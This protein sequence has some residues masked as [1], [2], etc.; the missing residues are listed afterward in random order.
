MSY[1]DTRLKLAQALG[2]FWL[3]IFTDQE[4]VEGYVNSIAVEFWDLD[5]MVAELPDYQSRYLLPLKDVA[6]ARLFL[7]D[8]ATLDRTQYVY[9]GGLAYGTEGSY[10][11]QSAGAEGWSYAI[12]ETLVPNFL[13]V[14]VLGNAKI[15]TLNVDYTVADG[16][17]LFRDNPLE[18]AGLQILPVAADGET[19]IKFLLWG[20]K[21]ER[22]LRAV[23][24][25]FGVIGGVV[26]ASTRQYQAAVNIA[27]DLRVD[28]ASKQNT[29]R[30][31]CLITDTDY[32]AQAGQVQ[33]V[34]IEGD[35]Q[36]VATENA[37][38][39]APLGATV[40]T[41]KGATL[42][43]GDLIF[44]SYAVRYEKEEVDFA[45]FGG[46]LLDKGLLGPGYL[47]GVF[48]GNTVV[49]VT[50]QHAPDWSYVEPVI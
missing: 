50:K 23:Q 15:L 18:I 45:D 27:W 49:P 37:V 34:F 22:D 13:T 36:C 35:R 43:V 19:K 2:F 21:V 4:F 46:L 26:A 25:F 47:S 17:I 6:D 39:T 31:L 33:A 32:V 5:R 40:L 24:N 14:G 41:V 42:A 29:N 1:R 3:R 8:E 16:R 48:A 30:V 28:G 10:G 9:G 44:D 38:Y 12:D 7:F 11:Q 20:F